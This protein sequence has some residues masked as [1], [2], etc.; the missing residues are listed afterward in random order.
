VEI[1]PRW[2]ADCHDPLVTERES[3]VNFQAIWQRIQRAVKLEPGVYAEIGGDGAATGQAI[4][5]VGVASLISGLS[6]LFTSARFSFLGWI[7]GAALAAT[8]GLAIGAGILWLVSRLFGATGSFESLF[9]SLG[10]A[11]APSAL[12]II[13][14]LGGLV[15]GIWSLILAIRAVKE[16]QSVSDGAAIAIVLIPAAIVF[17]IGLVVALIAGLAFLGFAATR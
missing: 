12:G 13:P 6:A 9:R 16:T 15:G 2:A 4:A 17:V 10:F 1:P 5:V 7:I 14:F 11:A 8:V 3:T